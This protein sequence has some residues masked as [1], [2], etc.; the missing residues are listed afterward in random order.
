MLV[1]FLAPTSAL[2]LRS[3]LPTEILEQ[4]FLY[5]PGRDIIEMHVVRCVIVISRVG[6][7]VLPSHGLNQSTVPGPD[8]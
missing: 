8:S 3:E 7:D 6:V 5:L 4:I 2:I 1:L